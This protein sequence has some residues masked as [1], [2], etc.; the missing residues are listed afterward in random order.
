MF[1]NGQK[2]VRMFFDASE[3]RILDVHQLYTSPLKQ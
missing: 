1:K 3:E 2:S